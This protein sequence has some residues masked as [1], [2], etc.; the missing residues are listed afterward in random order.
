[1]H[2]V[3]KKKKKNEEKRIVLGVKWKNRVREKKKKKSYC[4]LH[5]EEERSDDE[6][7]HHT[8]W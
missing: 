2:S 3:G 1:M 6:G 8:T 4:E 7:S 5:P